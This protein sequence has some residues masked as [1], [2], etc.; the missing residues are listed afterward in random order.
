MNKKGF[1]LIELLV[2]IAIIGIL[3]AVVLVSLSSARNKARDASAKSSLSSAVAAAVMCRDEGKNVLAYSAGAAI[4]SDTAV[5]N[6]VW[7]AMPSGFTGTPV[8]SGGTTDTWALTATLTNGKTY[9]CT[10]TG[11]IES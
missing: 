1:T 5:T 11:C 8:L 7:P 9:T 3:A 4:C 10:Q 2:V 6:S